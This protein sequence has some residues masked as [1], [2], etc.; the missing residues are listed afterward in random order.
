MDGNPSGASAEMIAQSRKGA[1]RP[2]RARGRPA[3]GPAG[4]G[5]VRSGLRPRRAP[6][7]HRGVRPPWSRPSV[8]DPVP[9]ALRFRRPPGDVGSAIPAPA[10][11]PALPP[12]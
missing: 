12:V 9:V 5:R 1:K 6:E 10:R 11:G 4:V 8:A 7:A 3:P 2:Y